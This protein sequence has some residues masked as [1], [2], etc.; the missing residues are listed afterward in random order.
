M[1]KRLQPEEVEARLEAGGSVF[2]VDVREPGEF[3]EVRAKNAVNVPLGEVNGDRVRSIGAD[4]T[5]DIFLICRSGARSMRAAESLESAG[6]ENLY[7][8][9]GGTLAW[10]DANL[11][12][13]K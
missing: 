11:P 1:I 12:H 6:F 10:V 3:E 7:N 2:L 13:E 9:E 5:S 4:L 8:V